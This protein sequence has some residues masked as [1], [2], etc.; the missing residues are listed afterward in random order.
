MMVGFQIENAQFVIDV[1]IFMVE[2]DP[3]VQ[4]KERFIEDL[5]MASKQKIN[6]SKRIS[7]ENA[8]R[9]VYVNLHKCICE[10]CLSSAALRFL[11]VHILMQI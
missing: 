9:K 10:H 1:D 8:F 11:K 5:A 4:D 6:L 2:D 3:S 7:L